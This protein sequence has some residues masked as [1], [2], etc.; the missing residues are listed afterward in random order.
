MV[1]DSMEPLPQCAAAEINEPPDGQ[2][3]QAKI[4]EQLLTVNPSEFLNG[5]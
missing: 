3:H 5:F 2:I 1:G 4:G